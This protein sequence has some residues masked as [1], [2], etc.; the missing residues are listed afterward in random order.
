[1]D[2]IHRHRDCTEVVSP[3]NELLGGC[4]CMPVVSQR[5]GSGQEIL[6][7]KGGNGMLYVVVVPVLSSWMSTGGWSLAGRHDNVS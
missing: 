1:M 3:Y 5:S 6:V 4:T 2:R 7:V